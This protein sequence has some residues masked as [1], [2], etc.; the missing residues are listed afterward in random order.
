MLV[1]SRKETDKIMFPTLGITV[2]V[3]RIRGNTARLGIDAPSD[4]PIQRHELADL[5]SIDFSSEEDDRAKLSGLLHAVR[6]RLDSAALALNR[7]HQHS[8]DNG[9]ATAQSLILEVFHEL[10]SLAQ[11]TTDALDSSNTP[12]AQVL[13]VENDDNEGAWLAGYLRLNRFDVTVAHDGED[14]LNYLSLHAPPEVILLGMRMPRCDGPCLVREI[15]SNKELAQAKLFAVSAEDPSSLDIPTG[16]NGV[17][18]WFRKPV[19]AEQLVSGIAK[20]L[21]ITTPPELN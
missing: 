17:D 2:E 7:L 11:D 8:D 19:D 12:V 18:G 3:L 20:E 9:D 1:L 15:R 21:G 5:K 4:I 6:R 10:Q 13:L 14:A 16:P